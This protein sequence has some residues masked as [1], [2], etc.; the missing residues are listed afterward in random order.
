MRHLYR[1][2]IALAAVAGLLTWWWNDAGQHWL[3]I[4][5]GTCP[6]VGSCNSG[7]GGHY[8]YWSGFGSVFPWVLLGLG[9]IFTAVGLHWRHV[10]CH[11]KGCPRI[12]R[13]PAAGGDFRYC[14][15]HHPDWEGKHPSREHILA[16]HER[17][18]NGKMMSHG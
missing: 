9:G 16:R 4:Q 3:A 13:F 17:H 6:E 14:G 10:N 12:G 5:T 7:T 18:R 2:G 8:G 1:W 15:H 11:E